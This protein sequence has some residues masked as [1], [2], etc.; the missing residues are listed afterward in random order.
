MRI[1]STL[2]CLLFLS[3]AIISTASADVGQ[4][5]GSE[6]LLKSFDGKPEQARMITRLAGEYRRAGKYA[7][8][9]RLYEDVIKNHS[10]SSFVLDA[11]IG[12]ARV[13][14]ELGE[15]KKARSEFDSLLN[16]YAGKPELAKITYMLANEYFRIGDY[17]NAKKYYDS[18]KDADSK[19]YWSINAKA[20]SIISDLRLGNYEQSKGKMDSFLAANSDN[21]KLSNFSYRFANEYL[22][23]DRYEDAQRVY[24][25]IVDKYPMSK[26]YVKSMIALARIDFK[27]GN[28]E[29]GSQLF[30]QLIS[31]CNKKTDIVPL[32][33]NYA[34][35]KYES[36]DYTKARELYAKIIHEHPNDEHSFNAL[37][38]VVSSD[39]KLK[40][41]TTAKQEADS[42][43][44]TFSGHSKLPSIVSRI[45][46]EYMNASKYSDA[47]DYYQRIDSKDSASDFAIDTKVNL[48]KCAFRLS[49]KAQGAAIFDGLLVTCANKP[50]LSS[51]MY[52]YANECSSSG[53]YTKAKQLYERVVNEYPDSKRCVDARIEIVNT[54][55]KSGNSIE[56]ENLTNSLFSAFAG[57]PEESKI[58]QR[59]GKV[60]FEKGQYEKSKPLYQRVLNTNP[61]RS[62][63][64]D[65][66]LKIA[67]LDSKL[68]NEV[69][70]L[71]TTLS[72]KL[73]V[74][75]S[76]D[77]KPIE[78]TATEQ[79]KLVSFAPDPT[80]PGYLLSRLG[81]DYYNQAKDLKKSGDIEAAREL[82]LK[83]VIVL[84]K[85]IAD[86]SDPSYLSTSYYIMGISYLQ[87]GVYFK[88]DDA[89]NASYKYDPD[90]MYADS[91]L[92]AEAACY[93][94]Q[95]KYAGSSQEE[96]KEKIEKLYMQLISNFPSSKYVSRAEAWLAANN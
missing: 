92:Y 80:D 23:A 89:F 29:G 33:Y 44:A 68:G 40:S 37:V 57:K 41:Y 9:R 28:Y 60:Y 7:D 78:I 15:F 86:V 26:E 20:S 83:N 76:A 65:A 21:D 50:R 31:N 66:K 3:S 55:I 71:P 56:A 49:D 72:D 27:Q 43:I 82:F 4:L 25:S 14:S 38:G 6:K 13:D 69:Q 64:S 94:Q 87:L 63:S 32:L 59:I 47:R 39:L 45:A 91:C 74:D 48:A 85:G 73:G 93:R 5:S 52:K 30:E 35:E 84:N 70:M 58:A 53:D 67:I 34:N 24:R 11:Q 77:V 96:I 54:V 75:L 95:L 10:T 42:F 81:E 12:I 22:A 17:K 46:G 90:F 79:S 62:Q 2:V 16:A 61:T 36:K 19:S 18:V 1:T 88:A 51:I 8:S